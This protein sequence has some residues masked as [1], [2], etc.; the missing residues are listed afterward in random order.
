MIQ[1]TL[2]VFFNVIIF[3]IPKVKMVCYII[4]VTK[5]FK[6]GES[7]LS[8][9]NNFKRL[10]HKARLFKSRAKSNCSTEYRKKYVKIKN[11]I[12]IFI[13]KINLN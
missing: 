11:L 9:K 10:P 7:Y 12:P 8:D 5:H 3:Y 1:A 6:F 4:K 2:K 13:L